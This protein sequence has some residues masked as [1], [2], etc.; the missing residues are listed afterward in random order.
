MADYKG[1]LMMQEPQDLVIWDKFFETCKIKTFIELGTGHGGATLYFGLQ[2]HARKIEFHTFD[3]I[4]STDFS[5]TV[6]QEI[7]LGKSFKCIDIFSDEGKTLIGQLIENS[8]KPLAIFFDDGN[9]PR[10]WKTFGPLTK[11]GD[12]C[13]VHDWGTEFNESDINGLPVERI[14]TEESD[15]R[16][17]GWKAMWFKR[18][19]L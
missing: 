1:R 8:P 9:K 15:A 12:Y 17:K 10:E 5:M 14:L 3:N 18:I 2:C 19:Y 13:I 4:Q 11:P 7:E 16:G 6:E